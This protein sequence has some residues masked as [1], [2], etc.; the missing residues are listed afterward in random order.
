M[1]RRVF[2][3]LLLMLAPAIGAERAHVYLI[4][5]DGLDAGF[6]TREL[7]PVLFTDGPP[8]TI[9]ATM[10]TRTNPSHVSLFTGV[11][12]DAHGV[13]GNTYWNRVAGDPP[14]K[15]DD[16][17]LI[18]VE[19]LF[20]VAETTSPPLMTMGVFGKPK[21]GRLFASV[22]E[23]QRAPD[24]HWTPE[25][26]ARGVDPITHYADDATTMDALLRLTAEREPDLAGVNLAD[27]D[28][29]AHGFGPDDPRRTQ[30]VRA[31]NTALMR[32]LDALHAQGRWDRSIVF[33]TADHGF[34]QVAPSTAV[35]DPEVDLATVLSRAGVTGVVVATDGGVAHLYAATEP[36]DTATLA[37]AAVVVRDTPGVTEVLARIAVPGVT[38]LATAHPDW[39]LDNPRTGELL[40]VAAPGHQFVDA[41]EIRLRGNHGS[42]R[43]LHI[44]LAVLGGHPS[45]AEVVASDETSLAD[46]G[47]TATALLGLRA[48][49]RVGGAPVPAHEAGRSLL[50]Q[51]PH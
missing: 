23:R 39:H 38:L 17:T 24:V 26:G 4:V 14:A 49:R 10:P 5:V 37:R 35:P 20:T 2:L 11:Y 36:P 7:M 31:A 25:P 43:E 6:V 27:V 48:P 30:A 8:H 13:T 33:V 1:A 9:R 50:R 46:V 32:F 40:A 28:R 34:D 16:P 42:P 18:E 41:D 21:L 19:T 44:P 29:T 12:P 47:A 3:L 22:P 15:T 51:S 45:R